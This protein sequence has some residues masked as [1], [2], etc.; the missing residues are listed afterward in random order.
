MAGGRGWAIQKVPEEKG[1][2]VLYT[3]APLLGSGA[4]RPCSLPVVHLPEL[5]FQCFR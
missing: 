2:S 4:Q 3:C 1:R 5:T